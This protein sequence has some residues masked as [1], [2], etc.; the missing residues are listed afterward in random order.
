MKQLLT[1]LLCLGFFVTFQNTT[2]DRSYYWLWWVS[3]PFDYPGPVNLAGGE[4]DPGEANTLKYEYKPG[5]YIASWETADYQDDYR[6][7]IPFIVDKLTIV[8]SKPGEVSQQ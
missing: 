3:H 2:S 6:S 7:D 4:L 5:S 8:T 1:F